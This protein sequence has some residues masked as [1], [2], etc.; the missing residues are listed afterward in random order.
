MLRLPAL[1]SVGLKCVEYL[2][3]NKQWT[4]AQI[5]NYLK[6]MLEKRNN[7]QESSSF[8]S[9]LN[10]NGSNSFIGANSSINS[11]NDNHHIVN[12]T[13]L[14]LN[15]NDMSSNNLMNVIDSNNNL[16]NGNNSFNDLNSINS[17]CIN[18][19]NHTSSMNNLIMNN[20]NVN[21][22]IN[23]HNNLYLTDLSN[24]DNLMRNQTSTN[25]PMNHTN[26][27]LSLT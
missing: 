9:N 4:E 14:G 24:S 1:R 27:Q 23:G 21:G 3:I 11:I 22:T 7:Y 19:M 2:F 25:L 18:F 15:L 10:T 6:L 26:S 16:T 8:Q 12:Q 5:D 20:N 13:L 17:S